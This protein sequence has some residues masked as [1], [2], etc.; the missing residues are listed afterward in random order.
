M[1]RHGNPLPSIC[2]VSV[3]HRSGDSNCSLRR[4]TTRC[5][6]DCNVI[7]AQQVSPVFRIDPVSSIDLSDDDGTLRYWIMA[8]GAVEQSRVIDSQSS[9]TKWQ[10]TGKGVL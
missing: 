2:Y 10:H 4:T 5:H 8:S 7:N 1:L 3:Q 6:L 9:V